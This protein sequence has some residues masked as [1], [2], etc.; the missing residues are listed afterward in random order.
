MSTTKTIYQLGF[1]TLTATALLLSGCAQPAGEETSS[2]T[3]ENTPPV[4]M[5]A[6]TKEEVEVETQHELVGVWWGTG[7]LDQES[8]N[9]AV[10]GLS[11]ETRRQVTTAAESFL[12]TEMAIEFK[13]DGNMD[14]AVEVTSRSG[15]RESGMGVATWEASPTINAGEYSVKA[16]E[17]QANGLEVTDY[18]TYRVSKDGSQLTLLVDLPGLLGQCNPRIVLKRQEEKKNVASAQGDLLR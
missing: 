9:R 18:K 16:V 12:E 13:P 2:L 10:E 1:A 15:Q 5:A 4:S 11:A 6:H 17:T 3:I 7:T 14:T 8:L